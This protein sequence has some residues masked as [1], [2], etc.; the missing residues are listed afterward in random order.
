MLLL[1]LPE[2]YSPVLGGVYLVAQDAGH[3]ESYPP[4][5]YK[6]EEHAQHVANPSI[7]STRHDGRSRCC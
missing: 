3:H 2:F 6:S 7:N 5:L 1:V 4:R